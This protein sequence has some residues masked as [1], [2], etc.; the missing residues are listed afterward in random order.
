MKIHSS[1]ISS[2]T[3]IGSNAFYRCL[4]LKEISIPSTIKSFGKYVFDEIEFLNIT[5]EI[6]KI[7]DYIFDDNSFLK[8]ITIP[9]SVT[10]IGNYS[11]HKCKSFNQ[12]SIPPSVT[13]FFFFFLLI[14]D[15]SQN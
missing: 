11:F 14:V 12:I 7:P 4:S 3:S 2:V 10:Y 1:L 8:E 6:T 9:S 13:F 15:L 5:G